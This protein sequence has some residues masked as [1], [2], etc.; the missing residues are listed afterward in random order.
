MIA[1]QEK[2][3]YDVNMWF[4]ILGAFKGCQDFRVSNVK[5]TEM[6]KR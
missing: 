2:R 3:V 5:N 6:G 1:G 4:Y